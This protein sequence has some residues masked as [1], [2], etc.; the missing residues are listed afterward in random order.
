MINHTNKKCVAEGSINKDSAVLGSNKE[1]IEKIK[2]VFGDGVAYLPI[3]WKSKAPLIN[4][5]PDILPG[6]YNNE[7]FRGKNIGIVCGENSSGLVSIDCDTKNGLE[8][9]LSLNPRFAH[10]TITKAQRGGNIWL[11]LIDDEYPR[12]G[13]LYDDKE[14]AWGEFRSTGGQTVV[15]GEHRSG[16][17]YEL[18]TEIPPI[19][20]S[21]KEIIW[22]SNLRAPWIRSPLEKI[23]DEEGDPFEE[24]L[25]G[26]IKFNASFFASYYAEKNQILWISGEGTFYKYC[27]LTGVWRPEN[28]DFL[29]EKIQ[30]LIKSCLEKQDERLARAKSKISIQLLKNIVEFLKG[31]VECKRPFGLGGNYLA[32]ENGV[33]HLD[34]DQIKLLP[35]CPDYMLLNFHE[36]KYPQSIEPSFSEEI[37]LKGL[38]NWKKMK[39]QAERGFLKMK[40]LGLIPSIFSSMFQYH[41]LEPTLLLEFLSK[42]LSADDIEL[43]QKYGG[44]VLFGGNPCQ[45]ILLILG[46]AGSGKG[47][48]VNLLEKMIG[49]ENVVQLRTHQLSNRFE[50]ARFWGKKLLL[51]QDVDEDFLSLTQSNDLKSLVGH[52]LISGEAKNQ[53]NV[54]QIRG[55]FGVVISSNH[56]L[57]INHKDDLE[58]W[59]RRLFVLQFKEK[60]KGRKIPNFEDKLIEAEGDKIF[61]WFV[62]GRLKLERDIQ[63]SGDFVINQEQKLAISRVVNDSDS[64][65]LFLNSCVEKSN[66]GVPTVEIVERYKVFCEENGFTQKSKADV[67]KMLPKLMQNLHGSKNVN[68]VEN[69]KGMRVRGYDRIRLKDDN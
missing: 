4:N 60:F 61:H 26:S 45:K 33:I 42:N 6:Q 65:R 1:P 29:R 16:C 22:P 38:A 24:S 57:R 53:R 13:T 15:S 59:K 25:N 66:G 46:A 62:Q 18:H 19:E 43:V 63:A 44:S 7:S 40:H 51:G 56:Q 10:T 47:V 41:E 55:E 31:R 12:V 27:N 68:S 37:G 11:K 32:A 23:I 54:L 28:E 39:K 34:G 9:M 3:P 48:L 5:W 14:K 17:M 2:S 50:T 20:I 30:K 58:A 21:F 64:L 8:E 52:D 69:S 35:H 49:S 67:Q 36:F